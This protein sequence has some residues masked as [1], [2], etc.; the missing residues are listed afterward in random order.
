MQKYTFLLLFF[1]LAFH[2]AAQQ[3][4]PLMEAAD[5][6][7]RLQEMKNGGSAFIAPKAIAGT[8]YLNKSFEKGKLVSKVNL[9]FPEI[10][11]RYNVYTDK[12]EYKAPDGTIYALKDQN[13]IK[14]YTIGDT[15]FIFSPY[16]AKKNKIESGYFQVLNTG[17]VTAL[18]RY[19]VFLLPATPERPYTPAKPERFSEITKDFYI[20]VGEEPARLVSN[21]KS[22]EQYFPGYKKQLNQFIKKEKLHL[23]KEADFKKLVAYCNT[24]LHD[25]K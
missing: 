14:T 21:A 5:N 18:V 20:K 1:F 2:L 9:K 3:D 24:L 25:K 8:P 12:I 16:Y 13:K 17:K 11:L 23:Q 19:K 7:W 4:I 22:F 10:P 6:T 15:T